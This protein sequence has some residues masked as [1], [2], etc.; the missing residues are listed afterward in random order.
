MELPNNKLYNIIYADPPYSYRDKRDKHPRLCGGATVHYNTMTLEDIKNLPVNKI[1]DKN[2]MLFLW[3]TFPNLQEGLDV[4]KAWGFDYRTLGFSWI[5]LNKKNRK[6][7]FG[8]GYYTKSN[9]ECCLIGVKGKPIVASNFVSSVL[10]S[11]REQHSKK[12]DI[13]REK[14][15]E[16]CGDIPRIELFA[17][18]RVEN[19]DCWGDDQSLNIEDIPIGEHDES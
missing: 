2:C 18:K 19:W 4:M 10:M 7:F 9:C 1:A 8:I 16:L 5:K 14:I 12:P 15:V 6:P 11:P 13:V 3:T 17:R